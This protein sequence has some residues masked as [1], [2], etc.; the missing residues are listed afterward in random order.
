MQPAGSSE[1]VGISVLSAGFKTLPVWRKNL[2]QLSAA[3]CC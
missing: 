3:S 1:A 2:T